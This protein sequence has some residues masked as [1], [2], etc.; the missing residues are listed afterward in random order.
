MSSIASASLSLIPALV[1]GTRVRAVNDF[2]LLL[3]MSSAPK[4]LGALDSCDKHRNEGA[5]G[6][7]SASKRRISL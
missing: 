4:D 7:G 6:F 3:A 2:F 1:T 5:W